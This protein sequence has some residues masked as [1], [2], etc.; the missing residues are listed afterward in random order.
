MRLAATRSPRRTP[1][2]NQIRQV[3]RR[4]ERLPKSAQGQSLPHEKSRARL[5]EKDAS[6]NGGR[7]KRPRLGTTR[8]LAEA[9]CETFPASHGQPQKVARDLI[10][11]AGSLPPSE[12]TELH[13]RTICDGWRLRLSPATRYHRTQLLKRLIGSIAELTGRGELAHAIRKARRPGARRT[14]AEP[15]EIAALIEHAEPWMKG[16]VLLATHGGLRRSDCLRLAPIHYNPEERTFTID[17]KK[18]ST[19]VTNP[20]TDAL[21]EWLEKANPATIRTPYVDF[22]RGKPVNDTALRRAWRALKKRAG[23]NRDLWLHD[24][25]RTAAVSLY[26]LTKDLRAV[27]NFLGHNSLAATCG[28]LEHR[29]AAKLKPYIEQMWR[30]KTEVI[31]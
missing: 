18:T 5:P 31:Q 13:V 19:L 4:L 7:K 21:A 26:E 11:L 28:Y 8:E 27:E 17:Q 6:R 22:Y 23:V 25:R 15:S 12:L 2:E 3:L 10:A 9:W 24:L 20:V 29:D 1:N 16:I 14:I 30:P